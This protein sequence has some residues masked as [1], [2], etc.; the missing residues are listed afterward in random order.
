[1]LL[2]FTQESEGEENKDYVLRIFGSSEHPGDMLPIAD[3]IL[4]HFD[5]PTQ[6]NMLTILIL[7][8]KYKAKYIHQKI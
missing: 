2:A 8:S 6:D 1:M 4:L 5:L 3:K 7:Y